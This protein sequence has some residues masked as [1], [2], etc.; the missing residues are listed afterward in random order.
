MSKEI[1][2]TVIIKTI[3]RDTLERS[4]E[5]ARS[6]G[7]EPIII[8]DGVELDLDGSYNVITLGRNWNNYGFMAANVGA[9]LAK[10]EFIT[11]LDDDDV[12]IKGA[13]DFIRKKLRQDPSVDIW[14][15]GIRFD[16]GL[17]QIKSPKTRKV[18]YTG[19]EAGVNPEFGLIV[20]NVCMPT[21]RTSIFRECPFIDTSKIDKNYSNFSDI[22]HVISCVQKGYKHKWFKKA[23]YQ[24]RPESKTGN[25][26][27]KL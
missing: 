17:I 11:F 6:E 12:F 24:V 5:S 8:S 9:A 15:A 13:G 4:I 26:R 7:F 21:Y 27:G 22:Y 19:R 10:T 2:T 23:L 3:G 14:L 16:Q 20:G 25:G 18:I 1:N